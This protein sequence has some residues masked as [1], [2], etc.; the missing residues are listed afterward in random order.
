MQVII[1]TQSGSK[2]T[3][4]EKN[5]EKHVIRNYMDEGI[6]EGDVQF[7]LGQPLQFKAYMLSKYEYHKESDVSTFRSTPVKKVSLL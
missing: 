5:G 2:Y 3:F 6:V 1:T 4:F 7:E